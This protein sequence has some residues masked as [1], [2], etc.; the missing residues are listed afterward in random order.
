MLHTCTC[1]VQCCVKYFATFLCYTLRE[2][3]GQ[4]ESCGVATM[5]YR[6]RVKFGTIGEEAPGVEIKIAEDGEILIKGPTVFMGYFNN[7]EKTAETVVDGWLYTG[8]VGKFDEDGHLIIM[9]RKKDIIITAGG[10]NITPSEIENQLKFSPY[11]NDA[12]VIGDQRKYLTALIMIDE[13]NVMEYAQE[14]RVPFTTFASLTRTKEINK[15]IEKEVETVN[16]NF[17]RVETIK[18]FKLIDI[19]LTTDDDEI[20]PT[21][22]LKRKFV[23]EK[24]KDLID[25]MY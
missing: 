8:D 21:G 1:R 24:F 6:D 3:Y 16:K 5:H 15:L 4:T 13:E 18:K 11:I 23:S 17:A 12:V 20:T 14:Q 10:K 9:D 2:V 22:K 7:P 19:L 25:S